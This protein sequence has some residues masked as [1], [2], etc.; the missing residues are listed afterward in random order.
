VKWVK[1]PPSAGNYWYRDAH[2]KPEEPAVVVNVDVDTTVDM[3]YIIYHNGETWELSDVRDDLPW[4]WGPLEEP[5]TICP[6]TDGYY[7]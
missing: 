1:T 2:I 5:I 7:D 3:Y 4:F 6:G